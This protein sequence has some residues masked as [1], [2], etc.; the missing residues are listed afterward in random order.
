MHAGTEQSRIQ[1][2]GADPQTGVRLP[3]KRAPS[4]TAGAAGIGPGR[5]AAAHAPRVPQYA[6]RSRLSA[7][8]ARSANRRLKTVQP[9]DKGDDRDDWSTSV[10]ALYSASGYRVV[11][12]LFSFLSWNLE[13]L[14]IK[15]DSREKF[16]NGRKEFRFFFFFELKFEIIGN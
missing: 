1:R 5:A 6:T 9:E 7:G 4:G 11:H 12:G 15:V 10:T 14:K 8:N 2:L 3:R 13:L 16:Q